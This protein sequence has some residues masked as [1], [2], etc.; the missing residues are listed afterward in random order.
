MDYFVADLHLD[1]K[2]VIEYSDRPWRTVEEMNDGLV[3]LWNSVVGKDDR[4]FVLGDYAFGNKQTILHYTPQFNG[5][6]ILVRGNHDA[7]RSPFYVEAGFHAVS[8]LP[9][10]YEGK[11][12]LSHEPVNPLSEGLINI[13]GHLHNAVNPEFYA[14]RHFCVS[15]EVTGYRP[16]RLKQVLAK[17]AER[18]KYW[19][20]NPPKYNFD[21][22][23]YDL[24]GEVVR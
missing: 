22:E 12:L 14:P 10:L 4:V 2:R 17:M 9:M 23:E 16:I 6:K 3:K 1:H 20:E 15:V 18:E 5:T 8:P 11:Y 19:K 7:R 21:G 13:H 24:R